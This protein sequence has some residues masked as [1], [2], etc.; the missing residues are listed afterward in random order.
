MKTNW[1]TKK[2]EKCL[3]KVIYTNK[4]QRKDFLK[5]G[6]FPIVSQEIN[7]I[8]GYWNNEKDLFKVE[9]S[10]VIFGDHTQI[11]KYIDFDF[12]LGAD[13]VK[14]LKPKDF[15]HP[16]FFYY[17]LVRINLKSLGYAR[18]YKILKEKNISYPPPP[19]QIR[20]V[21]I[22]DEA[23]GK[24]EIAKKNAER[25]L[26]NAKELF[27]SYLQEVF[28]GRG[29]W[30]EK[31]L[32]EI[33]IEFGRGKSKHRPRNDKKLY[34]G[35]YPFI[36]TGDIRN[37]NHFITKYSQTYNDVGL[38]QSKLWKKGT[39]CITIAANIAETGILDF[40]ACFPDSV[41]GITVNP[42]ITSNNY[43]EYLLQSFKSFI[44]KKGKGSAQDNINLATFENELFPFPPLSTQKQIVFKL[45]ALSAST[46]KLEKNYQQK[47][48]DLNELKK[49]VLQKAFNGEL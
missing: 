8:N 11:L 5:S 12:V 26:R 1:K 38:A 46:K 21:K 9:K 48:D 43:V 39:I 14:I 44:K 29:D 18:H 17:Q 32:K 23:F 42:K 35:K 49:S 6:S 34:E 28:A 10:I 24:M 25:N 4:I 2:F 27:E 15:L 20:I 16:K 13:G 22:I 3:D 33:S 37:C 31:T 30:K 45:D 40:D 36:Q 47:I 7:F 41:I 19:E